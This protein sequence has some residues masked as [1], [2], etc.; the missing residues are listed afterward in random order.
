M[1][2][3]KEFNSL[4]AN[5]DGTFCHEPDDNELLVSYPTR[6]GLVSKGLL[7]IN[8]SGKYQCT[9]LGIKAIDE[10]VKENES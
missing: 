5:F 8:D 2:T 1:I 4:V 7:F 3:K 9:E 10:Y 6:A